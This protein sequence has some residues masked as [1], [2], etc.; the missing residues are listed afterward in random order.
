MK[1]AR[2][3]LATAVGLLLAIP[4]S[5]GA[6]EPVDFHRQIRPLLS[7]YCFQCHGPD[8]KARQADLRLDREQDLFSDEQRRIIVRGKPSQSQLIHR[9]TSTDPDVRMPP[10][11]SDKTLSREDQA[12]LT[13]WIRQGADFSRHWSLVPP[14]AAKPPAIRNKSWPR[15]EID[16]FILARLEKEKI[17][18]SAAA[19]PETLARRLYLDLTGLPPTLEQ[20]DAFLSDSSEFR[21]PQ[22]VDRLLD[23]DQFGEHMAWH[24]LAAAR[25]SDTNG[26]QGDRT[27]TMSFWRDWVI[28]AFNDNMPFDKFTVDQLA[29]DLLENPS[30][31]QLVASGFNRN[32][33]LNGEGGR[34]P[35]ENR[36]EYVFDRTETTSTVWMGLTVGCARCHDHK[37]DPVSQ[38]EYYQLYS[39]FNHIEESGSVDAGGNAKPV[40]NVPTL[41]QRQRI[42]QLDGEIVEQES[43]QGRSYSELAE[44]R[45]EWIR[46]LQGEL[47]DK[48]RI[49]GWQI[50]HPDAATTSGGA[51]VNVEPGGAVFVSGTFPKR[52]DYTVTIKPAAEL[53]AAIRLEALT[54]R[55]LKYQGP[56]RK[57]NFVL[58]S[59][60]ASLTPPGGEPMQ[61]KFSR[62]VADFNQDDLNVSS[63]LDPS[64]EQGWGVWEGEIN[65]AQNRKAVFYLESPLQVVA[66]ST[67]TIILRQQSKHDDHLLGYFRLSAGSDSEFG[68]ETPLAPPAS[69]V[70][71]LRQPVSTWNEQQADD[72]SKYH[73]QQTQQYREAARQIT[74][75][76]AEL[77]RLSDKYATTM[78]MRDRKNPRET[79]MLTMGRYDALRK[80]EGLIHPDVPASLP[81]LADDA[82]ANR[83]ALARWLV[84]GDHPLTARVAVNRI[85]QAFFGAGLVRTSEDFGSQGELPSH[86]ALLDWLA[87]RYME[88]GWDTKQLIRLILNSACYRQQSHSRAELVERDPYN[89]LL[90]RAPRYR[91]PSH[92]IRDQA[93]S[94]SGLLNPAIGGPSVK[95][96]QPAGLWADFSFGKITYSADS[97]EKLYRRSLY[98]F[99]RRSLG[100]PNMFD[101]A[102]RKLCSVRASR[103]NTPLHALT[104]LNDVTFIEASRV[105]AERV[106]QQHPQADRRLATA[107]RMAT[108]RAPSK[109]EMELLDR[110]LQR[111]LLYYR[112]NADDAIAYVGIGERPV[113]EGLD[114]A[115]LAAYGNVLNIILNTD[116]A[117]TRE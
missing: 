94:L 86:P 6:A 26:Y 92:V 47:T 60:E 96:Y 37:F 104:L 82:P 62:T 77:D 72:L 14:T 75:R 114:P 16:N 117:L 90:A 34:I 111:A 20:L 41:E 1:A 12:L 116:E 23:A 102:D 7:S 64:A 54:S 71:I 67:L 8:A 101:E 35:E 27:R 85:W 55:G 49:S 88:H 38:R 57:A 44:S 32:H 46:R 73:R 61:L 19:G 65:T 50:L 110:A 33:P 112:E 87:T 68:L 66:G 53:L 5:L 103:T 113:A 25:Y 39:Y 24:W 3:I 80:D 52:D 109:A 29:G 76:R 91:L 107:F 45:A 97:G 83:L 93:L 31:D 106:M 30:L 58:T 108:S 84:S 56:G 13:R 28:E 69:I 59:F 21:Y 89:R 99:W 11:D 105:F 40:I 100:P 4:A 42:K 70:E 36:V 9:I 18:P 98:T 74:L 48:D 63:A 43:I 79:Y 17:A 78:V 115:E 15:N 81:P 51:A 95:P 22:L 10:A 2:I